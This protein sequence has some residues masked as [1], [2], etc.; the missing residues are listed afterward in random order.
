MTQTA[1]SGDYYNAN[2]FSNY[3]LDER[4]YGLDEWDCDEQ[5]RTAMEELQTLY[6][7]ERGQFEGRKEDQ[8]ISRWIAPVLETLGFVHA[9]EATLPNGGGYV[10][11][12]LFGSDDE[13][14]A[15]ENGDSE[16]F[17]ARSLALV[18]AKQW[19]HDFEAEFGT[20]RQYR[21]ASHQIKH[22]LE[23]TPDERPAGA[24]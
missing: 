11:R 16:T 21:N 15:A 20:D 8:H 18:E 9:S 2:L 4:I 3:Y 10:D 22:Y 19:E 17:F 12:T 24:S 6:E 13:L 23:R 5:A 1:I 14:L 7:R